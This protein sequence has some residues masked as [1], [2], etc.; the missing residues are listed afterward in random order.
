MKQWAWK[1]FLFF[2]RLDSLRTVKLT[3]SF[4]GTEFSGWQRQ[5]NARTIQGEIE[6]KLSLMTSESINLH[7]AGRTDAG[8]HALAMTAHFSTD[9]TIDCPA[10]KRGLNSL[11]PNSIKV[12]LAEEVAESFHSRISA[13]S[14]VYRYFFSTEPSMPPHRRLYCTHFP[15]DFDLQRARLCLPHI[16]GRHDFTSFEATGSRDVSRIEGRGAIRNMLSV[17]LVSLKTSPPE[18][19]FE[20]CGDGFLRKM[21]RNIIGS[22]IYVGQNRM[23]VEEFNSLFKLKD[24]SLAAPT[25]PP[26]GLFLKKVFYE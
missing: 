8:V 11:L 14:K 26:C 2:L 21:V 13:T 22:V 7:G 4:D 16:L 12:L 18:F 20:I 5:L 6:E 15:G 3:L 9:S 1:P 17:S 10:F 19:L 24:R 23:E 25:A